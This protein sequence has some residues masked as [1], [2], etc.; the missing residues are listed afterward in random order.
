MASRRPQA[1]GALI[2]SSIRMQVGVVIDHVKHEHVK[3][4]TRA[5]GHVLLIRGQV[6]TADR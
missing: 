4:S 6:A 5:V 2:R 3:K 1:T